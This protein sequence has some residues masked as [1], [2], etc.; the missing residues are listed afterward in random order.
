M[1]LGTHLDDLEILERRQA[2]RALLT[3]PLLTA[4]TA[5]ADFRLIRRHAAW[6]RDWLDRH[7]RW[8]LTVDTEAAR[9]FKVSDDTHDASRGARDPKHRAPLSRRAYVL[10]CLAA[11][12][13]EKQRQER[14]TTLGEV[15]KRIRQELA[16]DDRLATIGLDLTQRSH[17]RDLVSAL[18]LLTHLGILRRVEGQ[19]ED[20]VH[21]GGDRDVLYGIRRNLLTML[22]APRR[23]PSTV[24]A[25]DF[26]ARLAAITEEAHPDTPEGRNRRIR[27]QLTRRLLDDPVLY[28]ADLP[29]ESREYLKSQRGHLSRTLGAAT[30][31]LPEIR[32]EGIALVDEG[33]PLTD[34]LM[35]QEGTD[36]HLTLL[37]AE[38]L[39]VALRKETPSDI[40]RDVAQTPPGDPT[41][42][43]ALVVSWA[44]LERYTFELTQRYARVWRKG[45]RVP[46]AEVGLCRDAVARLAELG[47]AR[48]TPTGVIP[49][50][51]IGRFAHEGGMSAEGHRS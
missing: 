19:E 8:L 45:C 11:A 27:S 25:S 29:Q 31:L 2:L 5:P 34:R 42:H 18:R 36:G 20:Y 30:G 10:F 38:F 13:L 35:P 44:R 12:S 43:P 22:L 51:A 28:T 41:T 39:S 50:P 15:A 14:Q 33:P 26:D 6:L 48:V 4:T 24:D 3:Q 21:R 46:G 7:P 23:G 1:S 49:L 40:A 32:R 17:R 16:L 47:L 9:L 37:L